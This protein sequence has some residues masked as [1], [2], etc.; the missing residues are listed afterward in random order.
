MFFNI[1]RDRYKL[2]TVLVYVD[3]KYILT[4]STIPFCNGYFN[5]VYHILSYHILNIHEPVDL[6]L[7]SILFTER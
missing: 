2:L 6:W 1:L 5:P 7:I 3:L 4:M